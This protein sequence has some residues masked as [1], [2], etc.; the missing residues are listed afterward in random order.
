MRG[1]MR[2]RSLALDK[3]FAEL[4]KSFVEAGRP[5]FAYW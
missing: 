3:Q 5:I 4:H 1:W 2:D